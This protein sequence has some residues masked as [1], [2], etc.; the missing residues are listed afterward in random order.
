MLKEE[1]QRVGDFLSFFFFFSLRVVK[2]HLRKCAQEIP[3][4]YGNL[5]LYN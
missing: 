2:T 4:A 3:S 5:H 1:A